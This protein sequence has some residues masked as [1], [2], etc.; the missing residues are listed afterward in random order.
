MRTRKFDE[1]T[2]RYDSE[3]ADKKILRLTYHLL[4]ATSLEQAVL[5]GYI[6]QIKQLHPDA[7]LPAVHLSDSLLEDAENLR[8]RMGEEEF[9]AG[10]GAASA[11]VMEK[12]RTAKA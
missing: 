3:L 10:L 4:G 12:A 5:R 8:A 7:P 2:G 9:L 11:A 1:L 6:E